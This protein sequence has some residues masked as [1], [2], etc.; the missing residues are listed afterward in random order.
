[1]FVWCCCCPISPL[2][3]TNLGLSV[4][5]SLVVCATDAT[6]HLLL[7]SAAAALVAGRRLVPGLHPTDALKARPTT[8]FLSP[9]SI[10]TKLAQ[11]PVL[12]MA[13]CAATV[14]WAAWR[15]RQAMAV[16]L[17]ALRVPLPRP[18]GLVKV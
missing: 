1:M 3:D 9:S 8:S 6:R 5:R 14:D 10:S 12:M 18:R 13:G 4:C 17:V 15:G 16:L 11:V 2:A 7:P